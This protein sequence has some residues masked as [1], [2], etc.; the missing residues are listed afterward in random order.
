MAKSSSSSVETAC[1]GDMMAR[2]MA[3]LEAAERLEVVE[4]AERLR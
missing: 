1:S 4:W 3:V 2:S